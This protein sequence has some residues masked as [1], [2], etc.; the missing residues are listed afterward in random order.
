[1][2]DADQLCASATMWDRWLQKKKKTLDCVLSIVFF[3]FL[4]FCALRKRSPFGNHFS[5]TLAFFCTR[6][7]TQCGDNFTTTCASLQP[8]FQC[9]LVRPTSLSAT[10]E[11][12]AVFGERAHLDDHASGC[13]LPSGTRGRLCRVS[14]SFSCAASSSPF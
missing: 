2:H 8:L 11:L 10:D 3:F 13:P 4:I 7:K 1:M 14:P 5:T 6:C 9:F 12:V